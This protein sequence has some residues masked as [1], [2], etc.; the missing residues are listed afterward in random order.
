MDIRYFYVGDHIQNKTLSLRHCLT[1]EMLADYFTKPLQ[2]SLFVRLWNHIMGAEFAD[3]DHQTQRSVL[4][5]D[6]EQD[7]ATDPDNINSGPGARDQNKE[8]V[9]AKKTNSGPVARDQNNENL[10]AVTPTTQEQ[11]NENV[12][13]ASGAQD[14]KTNTIHEAK[15]HS[16]EKDTKQMTYREALLGV[17]NSESSSD[18]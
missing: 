18:F 5:C 13:D 7:E 4:G 3:G 1:E 2:G 16:G 14:Q 6:D 9:R 10:C 8:N 17:G 15:T 11:N 12:C